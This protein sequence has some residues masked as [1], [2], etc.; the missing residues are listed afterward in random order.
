MTDV[1]TVPPSNAVESVPSRM[2]RWRRWTAGALIVI[3]CL[4]VPISV[5]AIWV[6][7]QLLNTNRYVENVKPLAT[8]QYNG[9]TWPVAWT[10][11]YG[12]GRVF[13]TSLGHRSFGP[14]K[15]DPLRNSNLAKLV[16]QGI[17]WA[18]EVRKTTAAR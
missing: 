9:V 15:D 7:G 4:L 2:P 8:I 6:R 12:K 11:G 13:H 1:A 16:L 3:S 17:D 5:L 14:G 10:Y 18:A